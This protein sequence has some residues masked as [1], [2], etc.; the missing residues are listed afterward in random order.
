MVMRC[1]NNASKEYYQL[2][3]ARGQQSNLEDLDLAP[4]G[5]GRDCRTPKS[6]QQIRS[7]ACTTVAMHRCAVLLIYALLA[8]S[9]YGRWTALPEAE[10]EP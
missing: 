6:S 5:E 10:M 8:L 4:S 9:G 1:R 7:S 3:F 2:L